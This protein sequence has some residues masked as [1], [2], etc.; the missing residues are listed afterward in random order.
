MMSITNPVAVCRKVAWII[1]FS[2]T[3]S[4]F[5]LLNASLSVRSLLLNKAFEKLLVPLSLNMQ[6]NTKT[7]FSCWSILR[8]EIICTAVQFKV[9][10]NS[11]CTKPLRFIFIYSFIFS[12]HRSG[13]CG[14]WSLSWE[15]WF[16]LFM[17]IIS[18]ICTKKHRNFTTSSSNHDREDRSFWH[19]Y[20]Q[21]HHI[22]YF[23]YYYY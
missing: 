8:L 4:T 12:K 10:K 22:Q 9:N 14:I 13:S 15:Y 6:N 20:L 19:V 17:K 2:G 16:S 18:D 7:S 5:S 23:Y 11:S 21:S 3:L 1:G